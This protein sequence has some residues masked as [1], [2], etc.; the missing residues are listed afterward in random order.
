MY[1][2]FGM[3][4]ENNRWNIGTA[5]LSSRNEIA[6]CICIQKEMYPDSIWIIGSCRKCDL[7]SAHQYPTTSSS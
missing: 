3:K 6:E 1:L 2:Y 7:E 4:F 5:I